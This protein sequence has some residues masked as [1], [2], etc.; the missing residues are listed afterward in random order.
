ML[1]S[2][3][4]AAE[5]QSPTAATATGDVCRICD[6]RRGRRHHVREMMFGFRDWF[7]YFECA[8]CGSLQLTNP[9]A[10]MGRYYPFEYY[11]FQAKPPQLPKGSALRKWLVHKRNGAEIFGGSWFWR[12]VAAFRRGW[13]DDIKSLVAPTRVNNF[14]ASILEVGCGSG[15]LLHYFMR[16][17][18]DCLLGI[19]PYLPEDVDFGPSLRLEAKSLDQLTLTNFDFIIFDHSLEHIPDQLAALRKVHQLLSP[20]GA[21]LI[22]IPI[23]ASDVWEKY[24]TDW[25]ELDAPRHFCIHTPASL[26]TAAARAGLELFHFKYEGVSEAYWGS[27]LYRRDIPLYS[28][29]R[30]IDLESVFSGDQLAAFKRSAALS[31]AA[32][33]GGR[34]AF[35]LRRAG[36]WTSTGTALATP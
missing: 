15:R 22:R 10:D 17:G 34:G 31:N 14:H 9:P 26:R 27:E 32:G 11:A 7:D 3:S 6:C 19:D 21:C 35:Y 28:N 20:T 5:P 23:A 30:L 4:S 1:T 13:V 8:D 36:A 33:R 2:E 25:F 16:V 24:G 29:G 12:R 18:F